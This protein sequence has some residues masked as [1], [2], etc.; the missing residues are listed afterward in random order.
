V[1][2]VSV[3]AILG[4]ILVDLLLFIAGMGLV[5]YAISRGISRTSQEYI[6]KRE[7]EDRLKI[8]QLEAKVQWLEQR[9]DEMTRQL[10]KRYDYD[11]KDEAV[12]P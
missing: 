12:A 9:L 1:I 3:G 10:L 5:S 6:A 7:S 11:P 8:A 4:A 2:S